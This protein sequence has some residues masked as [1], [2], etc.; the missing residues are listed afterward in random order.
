[1]MISVLDGEENI[2]GK[3]DILL[4]F[5]PYPTLISK[6]LKRWLKVTIV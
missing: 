6:G 4:A 3:G 2:I 1:M 5:S